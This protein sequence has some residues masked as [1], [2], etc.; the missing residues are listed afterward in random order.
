MLSQAPPIP[1][2]LKGQVCLV[3]GASRGIGKTV[4]AALGAAGA[5][6]TGTATTE[7]GAARITAA[8]GEQG[9]TGAGL[10]LDVTDEA[11][12]KRVIAAVNEEFGAITVL[13]NNAGITG[14]NLLLRMKEDE[15]RQVLDTNLGSIYRMSRACLRGML[16]AG[17]GH[18]INITSVVGFT[19]NPGQSN[20]AA[21]KAGILGFTRSLAREVAQRNITVN[22]V[23]PGFIATDMT[24]A[25]S[26]E[27][28]QAM[29]GQIP[30]GRLGAAADV[31]A[32]VLF[33][34][35]PGAAYITG[36]VMHVN[37]GMFM[38]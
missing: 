19:G 14:D 36:S 32:A 23:A 20:Y 33:L 17:Q 6:V 30:M 16:K 22:A 34:A 28:K 37:G 8:L 7:E 21:A 26:D 2:Q 11:S 25:L 4:A 12:I 24:A 27:Q 18:I 29:L 13:V 9:I 35:S 10:C 1:M 38:G 5:T 31:A 15:W 3:T